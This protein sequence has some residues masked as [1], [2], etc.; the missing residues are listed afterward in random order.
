MP[1]PSAEMKDIIPHGGQHVA[2]PAPHR[3]KQHRRPPFAPIGP[4]YAHAGPIRRNQRDSHPLGRHVA[5]P[6]LIGPSSTYDRHS[7][8]SGRHMPMPAPDRPKP[9][10]R[11]RSAP[12]GPACRY[13]RPR[14]A[15]AGEKNRF[16]PCRPAYRH[17]RPRSAQAAQ[18]NEIR[19][20]AA[21]MSPRRPPP[22]P[23]HTPNSTDCFL[24]QTVIFLSKVPEIIGIIIVSF[25][26]SRNFRNRHRFIQKFAR[27]HI[28][29]S[30]HQI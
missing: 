19:P 16:A 2:M 10:K 11:T 3:P 22:S 5:M 4:T 9:H 8:P 6:A 29:E 18:T 17:A 13:A 28:H 14:S 15:Q 12:W 23:I 20:M 7:P 1:A 30:F 24:C 21:G 26:S 25:K 27:D